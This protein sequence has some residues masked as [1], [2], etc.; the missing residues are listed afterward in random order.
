ML[1]DR[2]Q[3]GSL[4]FETQQGLVRVEPSLGQRIYLLWT[5]R[6]FR[7]LSMPLLNARERALVNALFRSKAGVAS[8]LDDLLPVIGV[9]EN[10]VPST[11]LIDALRAE[12][13]AS[14]NLGREEVKAR[15]KETAPKSDPLPLPSPV[16]AWPIS[17]KSRLA[18]TVGAL[19][20]CIIAVMA[21]PRLQATPASAADSQPRKQS[22]TISTPYASESGKSSSIADSSTIEPPPAIAQAVT[23]REATIRTASTG[24]SIP[25]PKKAIRVHNADTPSNRRLSLSVEANGIQASRAPLRVVYPVCPN[26]CVRG[27]VALTAR[28]DSDGTVRTVRV[29]SG[30]RALA[31]A[32]VRAVR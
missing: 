1:L 15:C 6:H 5:F 16:F 32:A 20:I 4:L 7:Q 3:F 29:V 14:Q 18:M 13:P 11:V 22:D 28:V 23:V 9:V 25:S 2:L 30:S 8:E 31:T 10:F 26:G 24:A 12:E 27:A 17:L 19:S 21:W